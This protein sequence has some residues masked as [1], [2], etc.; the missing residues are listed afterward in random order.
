MPSAKYVRGY[1]SSIGVNSALGDALCARCD[2]RWGVG[3]WD[4]GPAGV[5]AGGAVVVSATAYEAFIS[6]GAA[7]IV[8]P[9]A[10]VEPEAVVSEDETPAPKKNRHR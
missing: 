7:S 10:V 9:P 4:I 5:T 6:K 8:V 3:S 1:L 2:A